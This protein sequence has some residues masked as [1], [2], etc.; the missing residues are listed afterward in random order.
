MEIFKNGEQFRYHWKLSDL[1]H[2]PYPY[3]RKGILNKV[4]SNKIYNTKNKLLK[5]VLAKYEDLIQYWF[6]CAD[7][8]GNFHNYREKNR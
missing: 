6:E 3:K 2:Q 7:V 8:L 4:L 5:A 1:K